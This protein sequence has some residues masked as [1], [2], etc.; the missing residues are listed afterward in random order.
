MKLNPPEEKKTPQKV[1][2]RNGKATLNKGFEKN[3]FRSLF[4]W[5]LMTLVLDCKRRR[6][7][8]DEI[9]ASD[10]LLF[11]HPSAIVAS[12]SDIWCLDFFGAIR[13]VTSLFSRICS[14]A[15]KSKEDR[16][17]SLTQKAKEMAGGKK[18]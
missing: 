2:G 7:T 5:P 12:F 3:N 9:A 4:K 14:G 11:F 1:A 18:R 16:R 15:E 17:R 6:L 10:N 8:R 13:K